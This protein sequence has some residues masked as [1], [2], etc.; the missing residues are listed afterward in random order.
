VASAVFLAAERLEQLQTSSYSSIISDAS[1]VSLTGNYSAFS[2]QVIVSLVDANMAASGSDVGY[3]KVVVTVFNSRLPGSGISI[4][5][6]FTNY[7]G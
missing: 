2:R 3:K 6:L 1:P 5:S 7:A 4:T